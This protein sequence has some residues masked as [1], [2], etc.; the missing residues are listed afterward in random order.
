MTGGNET[1]KTGVSIIKSRPNSLKPVEKDR[2]RRRRRSSGR[3]EVLEES[4]R[5]RS[6]RRRTRSEGPQ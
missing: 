3:K 5:R 2:R 1:S 6:D 4:S